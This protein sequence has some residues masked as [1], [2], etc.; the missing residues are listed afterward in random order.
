M[1]REQPTGSSLQSWSIQWAIAMA[2]P[3]L[4]LL[5]LGQWVFYGS[6]SLAPLY[7]TCG[8]FG[9]VLLQLWVRWLIDGSLT[10]DRDKAPKS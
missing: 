3:V 4:G 5:Y 2:L 9:M 7:W 1:E 10:R 6:L 8:L